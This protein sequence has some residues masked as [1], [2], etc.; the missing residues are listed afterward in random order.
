M[1]TERVLP[2]IALP[3]PGRAT[4]RD[5]LARPIERRAA[6]NRNERY[7]TT[8]ARAAILIG[9]SAAVYAVTLA[10]VAGLQA[11]DDAAIAARRQ[12]YL[13]AIADGRAANDALEAAIGDAGVQAQSLA[14]TYALSADELAAYEARL[15]AL[16]ALVAETQGSMAA[17]PRRINLP[18]VTMRGPIA[19]AATR[20]SGGHS[21]APAPRTTTNTRASG[22]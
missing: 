4:G 2:A 20:S 16:A 5:G 10:A 3:I 6:A 8:P 18:N 7:F 11:S 12:P 21:A 22:G 9:A 19:A 14:S 13:D 17:L 15:D 1:T